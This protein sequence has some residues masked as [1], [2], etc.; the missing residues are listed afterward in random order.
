MTKNNN[1]T[2]VKAM[3]LESIREEI[4]AKCDG[5]RN[6]K[7]V[8]EAATIKAEA[9]KLCDEW[10]KLSLLATYAKCMAEA[11][12][13]KALAE[14]YYYDTISIKEEV[15]E[16]PT[17]SGV[18][19][20]NVITVKTGDKRLDVIE[21]VEW[22]VK[23]GKCAAES[24]QYYKA[25]DEAKNT[26]AN[27]WIKFFASKAKEG[28]MSKSKVKDALQKAFDALVFIPCENNKELN[29]V[30]ADGDCANQVIGFANTRKDKKVDGVVTITGSILP[31]KQ[32]RILLM[33]ILHNKFT[34][35]KFII[36]YDD[37]KSPKEVEVE[38]DEAEA[39]A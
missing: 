17:D 8:V 11:K 19:S 1:N 15:A 28:K 14:K 4:D 38:A 22:S 35:K 9:K 39:E 5:F 16:I 6:A 30:I 10:N 21:F 3:T 20:I 37:K 32:W 36:E 34:G 12:P 23:T 27:E 13:V 29:A 7:N 25:V 2:E 18:E 24:K 26:I 31:E 33:D